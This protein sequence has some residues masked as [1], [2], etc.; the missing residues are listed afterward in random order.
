MKAK[1][2]RMHYDL[3]VFF[4]FEFHFSAR[5]SIMRIAYLDCSSGVSG[6][7]FLGALIHAGLDENLFLRAMSK[8][9]VSREEVNIK[10]TKRM[11]IDAIEI[12]VLPAPGRP[13]LDVASMRKLITDCDLPKFV[14]EKALEV[15]E[16]IVEAESKVHGIACEHVHLHEISG[17]D[18]VVDALGAA[19][20]IHALEIERVISSPLEL[21]SGIVKFSHGEFPVPALA[22]AEILKGTPVAG[23]GLQGERVTPTGAA[24]IRTFVTEYGVLPSMVLEAVGHGAGSMADAKRP[25]LFRMIIG[26]EEETVPAEY[27]ELIIVET[28]IDN[29]PPD[30]IAFV[31]ESMSKQPGVLDI[32]VIPAVMKKGRMGHLFR[33]L[34]LPEVLTDVENI[35]FKESTSLGIRHFQ[36]HRKALPR[37]E[38]QVETE[39]GKIQIKAAGTNLMP[40]YEDCKKL[41]IQS[42]APFREIWLKAVEAAYQHSQ[43]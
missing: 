35:L 41:A 23:G 17:L 39:W 19:F 27:E 25:N 5:G 26:R 8:I 24:I 7:M 36:V 18:T 14:R 13:A 10:R 28:N 32:S 11:G 40:E 2:L 31:N 20:G 22:T 33:V 29:Q 37:Y 16:R 30:Q 4:G 9:G 43:K 21:G 38:F 6:D 3:R 1:I 15:I 34:C 12:D 42:G